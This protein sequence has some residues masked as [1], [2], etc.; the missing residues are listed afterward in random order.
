MPALPDDAEIYARHADG[1]PD[2]VNL[3]R[4]TTIEGIPC[5]R[6][7]VHF[8]QDGR[9][10]HAVVAGACTV[11]DWALEKHDSVSL[12]S[13]GSLQ[14]LVF[15]RA[16]TVLGRDHVD[17]VAFDEQGVPS[18]IRIGD[19][20]FDAGGVLLRRSLRD[21]VENI[22]GVA[23]T[24]LAWFHPNGRLKSAVI[25]EPV[26]TRHGTLPVGSIVYFDP[27]GLVRSAQLAAACVLGGTSFDRHDPVQL[28][29][30]TVVKD[31]WTF[32]TP[33]TA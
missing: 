33:R 9:L 17:S 23:C 13:D 20:T 25:A 6:G 21:E 11:R 10:A 28:A 32:Y 16:R 18:E 14:Q 3:R 19:A 22:D 26:Q 1:A 4:A 27:D 15:H 30:D 2:V 7:I 24:Q 8:H 5:E 31:G 29:G 12:R